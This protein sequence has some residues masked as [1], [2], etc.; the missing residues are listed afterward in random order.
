MHGFHRFTPIAVDTKKQEDD[1]S[2]NLKIEFCRRI[3]KEIENETHAQARDQSIDNVT[4]RSTHSSSHPIPPSLFDCTL[5][6]Q[7]TYRAH[8]CRSNNANQHTLE[9]DIQYVKLKEIHIKLQRYVLI[10]YPANKYN[11]F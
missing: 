5:N 7:D 10:T 4:Y 3:F 9:D 1:T 6:A 8:W 2:D 11:P